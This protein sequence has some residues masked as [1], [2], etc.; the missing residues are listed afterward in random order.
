M[1]RYTASTQATGI[2]PGAPSPT[3]I[4]KGSAPMA[5]K[6]DKLAATARQPTSSGPVVRSLKC[7]PSTSTSVVTTRSAPGQGNTAASSP[8]APG[9]QKGWSRRSNSSSPNCAK[10]GPLIQRLPLGG[11]QVV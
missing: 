5:A 8:T 10:V 7:T 6:S 2:V 9:R 1:P 3:V 4:P 11:H